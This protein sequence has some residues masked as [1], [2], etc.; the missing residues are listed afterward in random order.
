MK[1]CVTAESFHGMEA[2]RINAMQN[3]FQD[4]SGF[5]FIKAI[6]L[7]PMSA[8][9]DTGS[10]IPFSKDMR[11][12]CADSEVSVNNIGSGFWTPFLFVPVGIGIS[13]LHLEMCSVS[14]PCFFSSGNPTVAAIGYAVFGI[15][16]LEAQK[17]RLP[18]LSSMFRF[19]RPVRSFRSYSILLCGSGQSEPEREQN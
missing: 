16:R 19:R 2:C 9:D 7:K 14:G 10:N 8:V 3:F 6:I 17:R 1:R 4:F 13:E 12:W 15:C 18:D 5:C 11:S